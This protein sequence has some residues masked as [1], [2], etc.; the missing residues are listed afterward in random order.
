MPVDV[1][2]VN[3]SPESRERLDEL[4]PPGTRVITAANNGGYTGGANLAIADWAPSG[5]PFLLIGSHDLHVETDA[6]RLLLDAAQSDPRLG[7]LGPVLEDK[8]LGASSLAEIGDSRGT[9]SVDW[10]S[11]TALLVRRPCARAIG[12]FDAAFGSYVEDVDFCWRARQAGWNIG[13]VA[14]ARAHGL[15]SGDQRASIRGAANHVRLLRRQS[16]RWAALKRWCWLMASGCR[17]LVL[18][19][20]PWADQETRQARR[21]AA[22][23][24]LAAVTMLSIVVLPA[25]PPDTRAVTWPDPLV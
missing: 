3:N 8:P 20:S 2:V 12:G 25:R 4:L 13:L 17:A 5:R 19:A 24:R 21:R 9:K 7:V 23:Q 1:T 22:R 11:G 15:G 16:G 10:L 18:A 14:A 6:V